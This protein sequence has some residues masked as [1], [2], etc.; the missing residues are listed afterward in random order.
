M[1]YEEIKKELLEDVD[2]MEKVFEYINSRISKKLDVTIKKCKT[3]PVAGTTDDFV[4]RVKK[5]ATSS[6]G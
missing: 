2:F 6:L 3:P 1:N 5:I 4:E